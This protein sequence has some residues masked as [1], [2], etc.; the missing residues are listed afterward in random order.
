MTQ[1]LNILCKKCA[2]F[3]ANVDHETQRK[4]RKVGIPCQ[5]KH[6]PFSGESCDGFVMVSQ[7]YFSNK[8]KISS[9][10]QAKMKLL[11]L[12]TP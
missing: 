3:D 12:I 11:G 4:L 2:N 8:M 1:R 9:H 5:A 6:N 7:G 10:T